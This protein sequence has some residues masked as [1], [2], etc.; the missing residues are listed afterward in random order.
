MC[1]CLC[2]GLW[3]G[4]CLG[5]RMSNY[6]HGHRQPFVGAGFRYNIATVR[7]YPRRNLQQNAR[8]RA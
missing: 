5:L 6:L 7:P 4:L 3:L 1:V 8:P 2:S